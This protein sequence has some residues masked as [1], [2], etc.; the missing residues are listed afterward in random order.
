MN[1]Y[2]RLKDKKMVIDRK[3]YSDLIYNR[4]IIIEDKR[5]DDPNMKLSNGKKYKATIGILTKSI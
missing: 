4:Q 5:V 3:E 1:L 2:K